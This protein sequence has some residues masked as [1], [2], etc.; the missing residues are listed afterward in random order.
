MCVET[1][2]QY[3][4]NVDAAEVAESDDEE[5]EA[6]ENEDE[7]EGEDE[8]A[9]GGGPGQPFLARSPTRTPADTDLGPYAQICVNATWHTLKEIGTLYRDLVQV[10]PLREEDANAAHEGGP[11]GLLRGVQVVHMGQ[12]VRAK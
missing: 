1:L 2:S 5:D 6:E 7:D 10:V 4:L 8:G 11:D 12:Q 3:R 9:R